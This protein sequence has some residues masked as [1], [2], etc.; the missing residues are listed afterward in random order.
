[1]RRLG[2]IF[3]KQLFDSNNTV[4]SLVLTIESPLFL[5]H[6]PRR[7]HI[8]LP[9]RGDDARFF[10]GVQVVEEGFAVGW[11]TLLAERLVFPF[12]VFGEGGFSKGEH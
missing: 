12:F 11:V 7:R 10:E 5:Q 4:F 3:G 1:L 2:A 8:F 6:L 9:L